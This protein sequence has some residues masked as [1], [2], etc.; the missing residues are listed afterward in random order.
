M[1]PN[2]V[3]TLNQQEPKNRFIPRSWLQRIILLVIFLA[4]FGIRLYDLQDPPLDFHPTRQLRSAILARSIY[5]QMDS[6]ADPSL[7]E[8]AVQLGNSLEVYEPP[9]L[10]GLVGLTY[11]LLGQEVL[12]VSRIL[13]AIFWLIGGVAL[14]SLMRKSL[15]FYSAATAL[16]F[17][18]FLPFSI[19]ASRSF[20]P[21]PWMVMW[22]L[23]STLVFMHWVETRKWKWAVLAGIFTS[24]TILVKL[25]AIFPLV[26]IFAAVLL[27]E[28]GFKQSLRSKQV[29]VVAGLSALPSLVFYIL[30][31]GQRSAGFFS[32]WT[33]SLS[34]LVLQHTFY[35]DWLAMLQGLFTLPNIL[36][37]L[38]GAVLAPRRL[39]PVLLG[40]WAG[41]FVYGLFL[42]YQMTTHEYYHLELIPL[43]A[44]GIGVVA[45][46][47]FHTLQAQ[48]WIWK[49]AAALLIVSSSFYALWVGRSIMYAGSYTNEPIAW[50]KVGEAIPANGSVIALTSE[51]GNR[52]M[53]YGW[54][55]IAG[56][57]PNNSDLKLFSLAG[58]KPLDYPS[59]FREMTA[60]RDYFLITLFSEFDA[61]P[62]LK[63]LLYQNFPV[64]SEGD[65]YLIFDLRHPSNPSWVR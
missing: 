6:F 62:E 24:F 28:V 1:N 26:G 49:G 40:F 17:Y 10:E 51:Y 23:I 14:F 7:R 37:A 34:Q 15:G 47:V 45:E 54:R 56:Y 13:N 5:Y 35:A 52:L 27:V 12:W 50:K 21:D 57:W 11:L 33:V 42:P 2:T 9:I 63:D 20:Q 43:V 55:G 38:F 8:K 32:F 46:T 61:Q 16:A 31:N 58:N 64:F 53:Y 4:G 65:G 41:Y 44:L 59:Y 22:I 39:K 48:T 29:W 30:N 18:F 36:L 19:I 25:I 60:G 3:S